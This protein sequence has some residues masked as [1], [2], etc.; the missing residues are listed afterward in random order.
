FDGVLAPIVERP[1]DARAL[2][3]T[4]DAVRDL[5]AVPDVTVALVSGRARDDLLG[6]TAIDP[7]GDVLVIGSHGAELPR[8]PREGDVDDPPALDDEARERLSQVQARLEGLAA[9][10]PGAHVEHKPTAAVLHTRRLVSG[11]SE[12]VAAQ[13]LA[14]MAEVT[15]VHVTRGKE[16]VEVAV[17]EASKGAALS[18]LRDQVGARTLLYLGDDVTDETVFRSLRDGDLGLKVGD[19]DTA[20]AARLPDPEAV[21]DL[22]RRLATHLT[23]PPPPPPPPPPGR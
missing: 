5:A 2:P 9:E 1:G 15:G 8:W 14:L 11:E 10:H 4:L 7:H 23:A 22:L 21:R 12:T 6:L 16:V 19:G 20:A 3:G 17:V 13:A 18:W